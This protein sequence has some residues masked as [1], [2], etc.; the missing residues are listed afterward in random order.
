MSRMKALAEDALAAANELC[1]AAMSHG[2]R[3]EGCPLW[4]EAGTVDPRYDHYGDVQPEET[5][6]CILDWLSERAEEE[7]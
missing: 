4:V 5:D 2:H 1:E 3:C 6:Y 7:R